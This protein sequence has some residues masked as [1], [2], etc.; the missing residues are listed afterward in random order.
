[1]RSSRSSRTSS[2]LALGLLLLAAFLFLNVTSEHASEEAE[3]RSPDRSRSVPSIAL[4]PHKS[5]GPRK[6]ERV[7]HREAAE[8]R[9][10]YDSLGFVTLTGGEDL[11][12]TTNT[13][14]EIVRGDSVIG[15][16]K[17]TTVALSSSAADIVPHS[18]QDGE[19]L[20]PGDR[21]QV[22]E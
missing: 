20:Q 3:R 19:I 15:N 8:I 4:S 1:M 16:L 11:G 17:I 10:V 18:M 2:L 7:A 13:K 9:S 22:I 6:S 5:P 12:L 21:V 14:L